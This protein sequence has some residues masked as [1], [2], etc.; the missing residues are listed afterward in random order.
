VEEEENLAVFFPTSFFLGLF[1]LWK[2]P[3]KKHKR[4]KTGQFCAVF[5]PTSFFLQKKT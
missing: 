4:K 2:I 1:F 3:R 5:F